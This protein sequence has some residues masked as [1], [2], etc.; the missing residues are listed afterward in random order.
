MQRE[1]L[2]VLQEGEIRRV[3]GKEIIKVDV[4]VISATNR[5]LRELVKS[6]DFREDL[7]YRLNVVYIDLP[8][9][10]D[11][12]EDVPLIVS[13]ILDEINQ[14]EGRKVQLEKSALRALLRYDWP[15][16]VRE[17]ENWVEKSVLMLE[18]DV[19]H[20][21]DVHLEHDPSRQGGVSTLFESDYKNAKEA[22]LREYLKAVLAR[23]QGNVTKAAQEAGIVRSSFHKMMRKHALRA[24]DFGG[25]AE[26][27][28][29]GS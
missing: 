3:G 26:P 27:S 8:P 19:I 1:L 4:R 13:R 24:R 14:R 5:D 15:G 16:N 20:E 18:G 11:R 29:N 25:R 17:L 28:E 22:F 7:F 10:R 21:G 2:R 6:G 23:N 12:K 9:L